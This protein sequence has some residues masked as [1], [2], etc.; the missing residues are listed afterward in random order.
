M[1]KKR[2]RKYKGR[3]IKE[4]KKEVRK[5]R[6]KRNKKRNGRENCCSNWSALLRARTPP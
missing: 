2:I 6:K 3:K 4:K 5:E 1:R